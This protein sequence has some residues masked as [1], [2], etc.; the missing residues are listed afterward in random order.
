MEPSFCGSA[1]I[2]AYAARHGV[3]HKEAIARLLGHNIWPARFRRNRGL[4]TAED[5]IRLLD[6]P[7]LIA[8][9]GGL[10]G[11][12]AEL[13]ARLG[14]GNIT[15]CDYDRFEESNLNRQRFCS[16]AAVGELKAE[17]AARA[18]RGIASFG[19]YKPLVLKLAPDNLPGLLASCEIVID[20]LDSVE[21]K[22][23]LEN[24]AAKAGAAWL[25]GSVL[26]HE[27]FACLS[28]PAEGAL[29]RLY[30]EAAASGAG[31]VLSHTVDGAAALMCALFTRWL[32]GKSRH[33]P[34]IHA[35]FS[36]PELSAF[37]LD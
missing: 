3:S 17:A 1:Q 5:Q 9:C 21:G 4:L 23:M 26:H 18:L 8:G 19:D 22:K 15:L 11:A 6:L 24:A 32:A 33:T 30:S 28:H 36:V 12:A 20:C 7:V 25:H 35:D 27:A 14:A 29:S 13:L 37:H 34:L 31:S 2:A 10:G 16:E